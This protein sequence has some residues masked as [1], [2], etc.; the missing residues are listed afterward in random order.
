[1]VA[2]GAIGGSGTFLCDGTMF[3]TVAGIGT[4]K[5][6]GAAR[7]VGAVGEITGFVRGVVV[8]EALGGVGGAVV[9]G[10]SVRPKE[11]RVLSI[12]WL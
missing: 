3:G 8:I 9:V 2:G 11:R 5:G 1:V 4:A 6:L 12:T 7:T 10:A